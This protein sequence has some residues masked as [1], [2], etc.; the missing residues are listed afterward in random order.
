MVSE[1]VLFVTIRHD[2]RVAK[3]AGLRSIDRSLENPSPVA[4]P[5]NCLGK[6]FEFAIALDPI[7]DTAKALKNV[8]LIARSLRLHDLGRRSAIV[9]PDL[10][11][12]IKP[13]SGFVLIALDPATRDVRT[14][15]TATQLR[16]LF[17][18]WQ[19]LFRRCREP[20]L[21]SISVQIA[22]PNTSLD[23]PAW[24]SREVRQRWRGGSSRVGRPSPRR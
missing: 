11:G 14:H 23:R 22:R 1:R 8:R 13:G 2:P 16:L 3:R 12:L 20:G 24:T 5:I 7:Q 18:N 9:L 15:E 10:G 21:S 4:A 19:A 6:S 17:D